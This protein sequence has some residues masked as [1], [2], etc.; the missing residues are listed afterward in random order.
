[1]C[2]V[3]VPDGA[4]DVGNAW[5][6][7]ATASVWIP[8]KAKSCSSGLFLLLTDRV[9]VYDILDIICRNENR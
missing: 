6:D 3:R 4:V 7:A 9:M 2:V 8:K 1:M 5:G